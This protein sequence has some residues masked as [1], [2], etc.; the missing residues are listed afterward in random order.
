LPASEFSEKEKIMIVMIG[1]FIDDRIREERCLPAPNP[2]GSNRMKRICMALHSVGEK[3]VILSPGSS[4]RMGWCGR[5]FHE[6]RI[7]RTDGIPVIYCHAIGLPVIGMIWEQIAVPMHLWKIYSK[8]GLTGIIICNYSPSGVIAALFARFVLGLKIIVEDLEDVSVPQ[9]SDWR[10]K[11]EVRPVLQLVGWVTMRLMIRISTSVIIPTWRFQ[12]LIGR[13]KKSEVVTGCMKIPTR[14]QI[15][16]KVNIKIR[17][18]FAGAIEKE[19]GVEI[20]MAM[21][22][23]LEK[24]ICT[25]KRYQFDICGYGSKLTWLKDNIKSLKNVHVK[26]HDFLSEDNYLTLLKECSLCLVLQSPYGRFALYNTPSKGY[27]FMGNGKAVI[28]SNVGDFAKLPNTTR[29]LLDPYSSEQLLSVLCKLD[30]ESIQS[31]GQAAHDYALKN[32]T[33]NLV[34]QRIRSL[35][36][37][38]LGED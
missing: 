13:K 33:L 32:W 16:P 4:M 21:F 6:S 20:L 22:L 11:S 5:L 15:K 37:R 24:D 38:G 14:V 7:C 29:I 30:T 10:P 3:V 28:V 19:H 8:K 17:V 35:F 2:A 36:K 27:E 23:E 12:P 34:G 9:L 25:A 1:G 26:I 31:I 18:L